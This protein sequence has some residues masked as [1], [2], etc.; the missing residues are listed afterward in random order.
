MPNEH[1]GNLSDMPL[2]MLS[3]EM[4]GTRGQSG[5]FLIY[6]LVPCC[7]IEKLM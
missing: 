7:R 2:I 6:Q 1:M 3:L 5:T 4:L